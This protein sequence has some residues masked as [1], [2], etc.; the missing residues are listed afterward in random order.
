MLKAIGDRLPP[1]LLTRPKMGFGVPLAEWF[2]GSLREMLWGRLTAKRFLE[3]GII[4]GPFVRRLLEEHQRRRRDNQT[5]LW[6][7]L[8]LEMW[9]EKKEA[10]CEEGLRDNSHLGVAAKQLG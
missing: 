10:V 8:V 9:L 2:R 5:W 1:E 4:S 3:Q 7:L 6:S